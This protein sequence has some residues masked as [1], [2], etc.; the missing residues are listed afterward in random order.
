[1]HRDRV[2]MAVGDQREREVRRFVEDLEDSLTHARPGDP[3]PALDAID[4]TDASGTVHCVVDLGGALSQVRIADGWWE[5]VGPPGVA[6]AV[7][8]K[9]TQLAAEYG[10]HTGLPQGKWPQAVNP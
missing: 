8:Q 4:G 6:A 2:Y 1:M 5:A 7:L 9:I 3:L 10:D